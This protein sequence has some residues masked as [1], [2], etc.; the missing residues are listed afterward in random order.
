MHELTAV[1]MVR[2]LEA[3]RELPPSGQWPQPTGGI[4]NEPKRRAQHPAM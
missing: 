1:L 4:G 2:Y 3:A